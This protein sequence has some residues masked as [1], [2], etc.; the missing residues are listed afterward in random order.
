MLKYL[1]K[2]RKN[3]TSSQEA[4]PMSTLPPIVPRPATILDTSNDADATLQPGQTAQSPTPDP[5][6]ITPQPRPP[7]PTPRTPR[8]VPQIHLLHHACRDS[9]F[10]FTSLDS[11]GNRF[12]KQM[13]EPIFCEQDLYLVERLAILATRLFIHACVR[14]NEISLSIIAEFSVLTEQGRLF[15]RQQLLDIPESEQRFH[16]AVSRTLEKRRLGEHIFMVTASDE[17][18]VMLQEDYASLNT[19][20]GRQDLSTTLKAAHLVEMVNSHICVLAQMIF[21]Q[22]ASWQAT[23][24]EDLIKLDLL[25]LESDT[26]SDKYKAAKKDYNART[27]YT[28][29]RNPPPPPI[30]SLSVE[31]LQVLLT[32]ID[33]AT[34][35]PVRFRNRGNLCFFHTY[36][37]TTLHQMLVH[38]KLLE[39][40]DNISPGMQYVINSYTQALSANAKGAQ[41][42]QLT[43]YCPIEGLTNT[44]R[45]H[46]THEVHNKFLN[47][48]PRIFS[49]NIQRKADVG[50]IIDILVQENTHPLFDQLLRYCNGLEDTK[51]RAQEFTLNIDGAPYVINS[52]CLTNND[53]Q[54]AQ[55][56]I[57]LIGST[58]NVTVTNHPRISEEFYIPL[59]LD[60]LFTDGLAAARQL[61]ET[62]EKRQILANW[63]ATDT[64]L[65]LQY[66]DG[67]SI[68]PIILSKENL[69]TPTPVSR[70]FIDRLI[71][72]KPN[73]NAYAHSQFHL[74]IKTLSLTNPPVGNSI[75]HN[76]ILPLHQPAYPF[77]NKRGH[78]YASF[79]D[80][81][82][83]NSFA[84]Y[85][86]PGALLKR[87][88]LAASYPEFVSV[89]DQAQQNT[90]PEDWETVTG[91]HVLVPL[92]IFEGNGQEGR[93]FRGRVRQQNDLVTP[94]LTFEAFT[95]RFDL[96]SFAVH[97]GGSVNSGHW[98]AY[99][100]VG[101]QWHKL[102]DGRCNETVTEDQVQVM[103]ENNGANYQIQHCLYRVNA[104]TGNQNLQ[105]QTEQT[106][107][108]GNNQL[109]VDEQEEIETDREQPGTGSNSDSSSTSE[110]PE[111]V[112]VSNE[113]KETDQQ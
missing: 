77:G 98:I 60:R 81:F 5:T 11:D 22:I 66:H 56:R 1:A 44:W 43:L 70:T 54:L 38:G 52:A 68:C 49:L 83:Q 55:L 82:I 95:H 2:S 62:P 80:Y 102:D 63:M 92:P 87:A 31:E 50:H 78:E 64:E 45:Q 90:N 28:G 72:K 104:Q 46:D 3:L 97:S 19:I 79:A 86:Y 6:G 112:L 32:E 29:N 109:H 110:D 107:D 58:E 67:T 85:A 18:Q 73:S 42:A 12:R 94:V 57:A 99:R 106:Q 40:W 33:F 88:P 76:R 39:Q 111:Y 15:I 74:Q 34:C 75:Q 10:K 93:R 96:E 61:L 108:G 100:K 35:P 37:Q 105:P 16:P 27:S 8:Q 89:L 23:V 113:H 53:G 51:Q 26:T 17:F 91:S 48:L 69:T 103:L 9:A 65:T 30:T 71:E 41:P 21:M 47:T 36:I 25:Y 101:A 24:T 84:T 7:V 59:P 20:F 13:L 4:N 14:V